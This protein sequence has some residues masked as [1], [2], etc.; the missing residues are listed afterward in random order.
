MQKYLSLS[1]CLQFCKNSGG[2]LAE[3]WNQAQFDA[4]VEFLKAKDPTGNQH[5][6]IGLND[7]VQEGVYR[8]SS[9]NKLAT[10]FNWT[11]G[12]PNAEIEDCIELGTAAGGRKW[13]D[14]LC[15][16]TT[17]AALCM[18]GIIP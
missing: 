4:A 13:N 3:F 11:P 6:W 2:V 16:R 17:M 10:Y 5:Y 1:Y 15:T 12:E 18:R 7:I 14:N 8:W 9:N